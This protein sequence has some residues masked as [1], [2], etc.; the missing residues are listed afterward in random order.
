MSDVKTKETGV[1]LTYIN[2]NY[3]RSDGNT[4]VSGSINMNGN[5]LY[6][7]SDPVNSQDV[8]T[9]EYADKKTNIISVHTQYY[10]PLIKDKYQFTFG[11]S[12]K[13]PGFSG[14]LIP[15]SGRIKKNCCKIKRLFYLEKKIVGDY[16]DNQ[17]LLGS[18]FSFF[19]TKS[20]DGTKIRL[21]NYIGKRDRHIERNYED[22]SEYLKEYYSIMHEAGKTYRATIK[23]LFDNDFE[24]YPVSEGDL[25]NI[26]TEKDYNTKIFI[27]LI[28]LRGFESDA[29]VSAFFSPF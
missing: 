15:H 5:T 12:K 28:E 29:G 13:D 24:N 7:V 6:N 26:R 21:A 2:N 17:N 25:I 10:G 4:P 27:N 8:A 18:L 19:I 22:V 1:S 3:I 16:S 23:Y 11:E 9:K 20:E 14:F